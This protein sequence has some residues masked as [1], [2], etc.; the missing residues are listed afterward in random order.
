MAAIF[1]PFKKELSKYQ[2][3]RCFKFLGKSLRL[4]RQQNLSWGRVSGF[5]GSKIFRD[6]A[7]IQCN[8]P[9]WSDNVQ[10]KVEV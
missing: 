1:W 10:V 5:T 9:T 7:D 4:H 6:F 2:V 8:L 3:I